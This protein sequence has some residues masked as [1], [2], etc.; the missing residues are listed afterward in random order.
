MGGNGTAMPAERTGREH[1]RR[2]ARTLPKVLVVEDDLPLAEGLVNIL[3]AQGCEVVHTGSGEGA[4]AALAAAH[5][6]ALVLD[7]GLPG[8]DGFDVLGH[9]DPARDCAVL[10]VSAYDRVEQRVRGLDL[11]ADD[12]LVKPFAV[13]ELEAR[14]R[15]LLRRSQAQRNERIEVAGLAAD[16]LGKRA[17]IGETPVNLTAREWSVL[18]RL[19]LRVGQVVGKEQLQQALGNDRQALSDNAIDV[20]ISR[21]RVK[22][23]GAG[24]SIR[25]LRGFGYMIEEPPVNR[26]K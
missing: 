19:L 6:D 11:G 4:V 10:I 25:T 9:L 14:I 5:F 12:Y 3:E 20:Y 1:V 16:L 23:A 13:A 24:V 22:L 17:W 21:L 8:I 15:A 7:I 18:T 26:T 2:S